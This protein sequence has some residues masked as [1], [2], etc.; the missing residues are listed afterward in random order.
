MEKTLETLF[1]VKNGQ[2]KAF[3][4]ENPSDLTPYG[5][6]SPMLQLTIYQ[7]KEAKPYRLMIGDKDRERRGYFAKTNLAE[8]VFDLEE[9]TVKTILLNMDKYLE[10]DAG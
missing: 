7:G 4:D 1:A 6:H 9:E 2:I 3:I 8:K 10:K 5:L